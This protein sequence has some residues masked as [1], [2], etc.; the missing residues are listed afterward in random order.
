MGIIDKS[1][2][3]TISDTLFAPLE[4]YDTNIYQL[5]V[6]KP[7]DCLSP[8]F[9]LED[10]MKY[11]GKNIE[12]SNFKKDKEMVNRVLFIKNE[13]GS[14]YTEQN[15]NMLTNYGFVKA[16]LLSNKNSTPYIC[17]RELLYKLFDQPLQD[18]T[19]Y[20]ETMKKKDVQNELHNM[21]PEL[22]Y[23]IKETGTSNVK[24]GRT[25]NV[26]LTFQTLQD[27]NNREL[28][29]LKT[30]L[31]STQDEAQIIESKMKNAFSRRNIRGDWFVIETLDID[32]V[33][34][35]IRARSN[36]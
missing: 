4:K 27:N 17:F 31:C 2:Q 35:K 16:I 9:I 32:I 5:R 13:E 1:C 18:L 10:V 8:L 6:F 36:L 22:I 23:F 3:I 21:K 33:Y 19:C 7:L 30:I 20:E 25:R 26:G 15:K 11:L 14:Y 34:E 29:I 24:M 28:I 12:L